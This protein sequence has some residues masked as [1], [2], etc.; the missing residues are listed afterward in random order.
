MHQVRQ[1]GSFGHVLTD[2]INLQTTPAK[3][4]AECGEVQTRTSMVSLREAPRRT[5]A[6][7]LPV[8]FD[9]A[10]QGQAAMVI[11]EWSDVQY[12]GKDQRGDEVDELRP[13]R[14]AFD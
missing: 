6:H 4:A 3:Y 12:L 8:T 11:Y 7:I 14:L 1:I 5:E 9:N 2:I 13:V 10:S